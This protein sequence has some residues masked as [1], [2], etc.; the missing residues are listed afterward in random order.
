MLRRKNFSKVEK[1]VA[2][3]I[4][5]SAEKYDIPLGINLNNIFAH[6]YYINRKLNNEDIKNKRKD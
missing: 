6:T 1:K 2:N 5:Q 3:I 4:C